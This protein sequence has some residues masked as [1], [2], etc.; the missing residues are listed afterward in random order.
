VSHYADTK[1]GLTEAKGTASAQRWRRN[2]HADTV[3]SGGLPRRAHRVSERGAGSKRRPG[4]CGGGRE[5]RDVGASAVGCESE[6]LGKRRG[7]T[8]ELH[9]P[10]RENS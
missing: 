6:R 4:A 7:L 3:N 1:A 9:G 8:G 5:T 2:G 10:V